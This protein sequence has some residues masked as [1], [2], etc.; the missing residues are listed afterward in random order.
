M[1][2]INRVPRGLLSLLDSQTQGKNPDSFG[3]VIAPTFD[4]VNLFAMSKGFESIQ[5]TSVPLLVP[6]SGV[7]FVTVP[8][9]EVWLVRTVT[10][11]IN[12]LD[13]GGTGASC[14]CTFRQSSS[15][16][17]QV[18]LAYTGLQSLFQLTA[19]TR[20]TFNAQVP[21]VVTGG[22]IFASDICN[23][24]GAPALGFTAQTVVEFCRLQA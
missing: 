9:S 24:S 23:V 22:N 8:V 6:T 1:G 21:L 13:A 17:T 3:E 7:A 11:Q 2:I 4:M 16:G 18:T 19:N 20:A 15:A 5:S 14:A 10:T 12:T